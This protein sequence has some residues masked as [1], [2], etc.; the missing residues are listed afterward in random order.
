MACRRGLLKSFF[1]PEELVDVKRDR[2]GGPAPAELTVKFYAEA[3]DSPMLGV[4]DD[5]VMNLCKK[6][7][8]EEEGDN[9]AGPTFDRKLS[10]PRSITKEEEDDD[11]VALLWEGEE[12]SMEL[13]DGLDAPL[14]VKSMELDDSG[15]PTFEELPQQSETVSSAN[16]PY[17]PRASF[18]SADH[19]KPTVK[20]EPTLSEQLNA[21]LSEDERAEEAPAKEPPEL[22]TKTSEEEPVGGDLKMPAI[23]H[24]KEQVALPTKLPSMP[25]FTGTNSEFMEKFVERWTCDVCKS[26]SFET[27]EEAQDHENQCKVVNQ[28]SKDEQ[29]A[30]DVL[31]SLALCSS[32][33]ADSKPPAKRHPNINLVPRDEASSMLSDYNNLLVRH[34][35]FFYAGSSNSS[36]NRVGLRCIHCK[37]HTS[38]PGK[39]FF[40]SKIDSISAGLG[41]IGARHFGWGKCPLIRPEIVQEMVQTKKSSSLQTR[42]RGRVGLDAYCKNVA[43]QYGIF[44][45]PNSGICWIEGTEPN[46]DVTDELILR[47]MSTSSRDSSRST[48]TV[49]TAST[50]CNSIASLLA[51]MKNDVNI[52]PRPFVPSD[53]ENFWEC[54]ECRFVPFD[55][56]SKGSV[57]F[58]VGEPAKDKIE[59]HIKTCKG[60]TPLQIPHT[61]SLEPYY[62]EGMPTIKVKWDSKQP[63]RSS[64][65]ARRRTLDANA[66]KSGVEDILLCIPEDQQFT[67]E[68]AYFTVMQLKKCYLTRAGGSRG[69]CQVGYPGLA[70]GFCA[71]SLTERRFFYTS[72]DHLRNS[73]SHIP[74]HMSEC[75]KV[76]TE[77]KIRLEELKKTRNRQKSLLKPGYHKIFI[78]R[79]WERLHGLPLTSD[80]DT[81]DEELAPYSPKLERST[82]PSSL[83]PGSTGTDLV[84]ISDQTSTTDLTYSTLLQVRP[85]GL[86]QSNGDSREIGFP[87]L[88]CGWCMKS[89]NNRKFFTVS[90][91]HLGDLLVT[92]IADHLVICKQCPANVKS[93]ITSYRA[94]HEAQLLQLTEGEHALCMDRVW[95]KL[96]QTS[97]TKAIRAA[98]VTYR[99]VDPTLQLV[100][101]QEESLVTPFTFFTMQ[102]V[103]PCNLDN[104]GNGARSTFDFGFPDEHSQ[105]PHFATQFFM[106]GLECRHCSG[107]SSAR[108]FF[109]RTPEIL[110]GNY[111]HIPN[112]LMGCGACPPEMKKSLRILKEAHL[113]LKHSLPKG[114]QK[115]FFNTVWKRLHESTVVQR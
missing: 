88:V 94:T 67:T 81:D 64:G 20:E 11:V 49:L 45:D 13:D 21:T 36:D 50:D 115:E 15:M 48:S 79:V 43:K 83:K 84:D 26:C 12:K 78:D 57:V 98:P 40:P 89:P 58:S 66:V 74:S 100:T 54:N 55:F 59:A 31:T 29:Q 92:S 91:E 51:S 8:R 6:R 111:A 56:R 76:P 53:T 87:G 62:G 80:E 4:D 105:H 19:P 73:F 96:I 110:A 71:G 30:A 65:R 23:D 7:P 32:N 68:F 82:L 35:E 63:T 42:E 10:I 44:D 70:C 14:F 41:T 95:K 113:T 72:A 114:S 75:S 109:Y 38:A 3:M 99:T 60:R 77:V 106:A 34:I 24:G 47:K 103:K 39:T 18:A 90:S 102:Q 33:E 5:E 93:Q 69:S 37:D 104:S 17:D 101:A 28:K 107:T 108:R 22:P 2:G 112:H 52:E 97:Q 61:A 1:V 46:F 85:Y 16:R 25:P 9:G 27:F 86:Q